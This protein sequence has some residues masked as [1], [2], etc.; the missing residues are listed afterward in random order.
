MKLW[1]EGNAWQAVCPRVQNAS[2]KTFGNE[3]KE[4]LPECLELRLFTEV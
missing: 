2:K 4:A 1:R 3:R